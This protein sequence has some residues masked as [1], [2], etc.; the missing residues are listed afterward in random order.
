MQKKPGFEAGVWNVIVYVKK[1]LDECRRIVACEE[2][3]LIEHAVCCTDNI[4]CFINWWQCWWNSIAHFL[5]DG[6]IGRVNPECWKMLLQTAKKGTA[7]HLTYDLAVEE[8]AQLS[9]APLITQTD[10]MLTCTGLYAFSS[11]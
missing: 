10:Q 2:P 5:H 9:A 1:L 4:A 8:T 7:F 6:R 11:N 3:P